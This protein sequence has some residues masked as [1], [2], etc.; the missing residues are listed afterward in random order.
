MK[1]FCLGIYLNI[2]NYTLYILWCNQY[3][4]EP[5]NDMQTS[6]INQVNKRRLS[7]IDFFNEFDDALFAHRILRLTKSQIFVDGLHVDNIW[8][9]V[10]CSRWLSRFALCYDKR[11]LSNLKLYVLSWMYYVIWTIFTMTLTP[12]DIFDILQFFFTK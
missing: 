12:K 5:V 7:L 4:S 6:T 2:K 3:F 9:L 11:Q 8:L 1:S 10:L